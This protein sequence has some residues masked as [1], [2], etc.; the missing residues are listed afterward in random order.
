MFDAVRSSENDVLIHA[1]TG[2]GKT[3]S[4]LLPLVDQI[5]QGDTGLQVALI[6]PNG[7]LKSQ[8]SEVLARLAPE[9]KDNFRVCTPRQVAK[10]VDRVGTCVIDEADM[11]LSPACLPPKIKLIEYLRQEMGAK[12]R[13]I[14]YSGATFPFESSDKSIRS[15][16]LKYNKNTSVLEEDSVKDLRE[17]VAIQ[18]GNEQFIRFKGDE[19]ERFEGLKKIIGQFDG[20]QSGKVMIFVRDKIEASDLS[21]KLM[22]G[23]DKLIVTTD[24]MSRG[25][26]IPDLQHVIHYYPPKSAIDYVHRVGRLNRLNSVIPK[27][28]CRSF[29]LLSEKDLSGGGPLYLRLLLNARGSMNSD[30]DPGDITKFFSRNRS[31]NKQIR[32]GK[33]TLPPSEL[34]PS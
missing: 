6:Q 7:L 29:C 15:Q 2:K 27:D 26:D 9:F 22:S 18:N 17:R 33:L 3:L 8:V 12:G 24:S 14:I 32:R 10:F 23:N 20:S 34:I 1:G 5:Y 31:I 16:I 25:I 19:E 21:R 13:R 28:S 11:S 30:S 4:Y